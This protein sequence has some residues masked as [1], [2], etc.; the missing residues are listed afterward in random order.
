MLRLVAILFAF[1]THQIVNG[2]QVSA[3]P[4]VLCRDSAEDPKG[5]PPAW[6]F[7]CQL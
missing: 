3:D 4:Q 5:S 7:T 2:M 1:A 6:E